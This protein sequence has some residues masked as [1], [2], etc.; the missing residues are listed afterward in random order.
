MTVVNTRAFP[1]PSCQKLIAYDPRHAGGEIV[2]PRCGHRQRVPQGEGQPPPLA[3]RSERRRV[4]LSCLFAGCGG[5]LGVLILIAAL[6]ALGVSVRIPA[7][8]PKVFQRL[9]KPLVSRGYL[10]GTAPEQVTL[11]GTE[12]AVAVSAVA[13]KC[14]L[15]YEAP[16]KRTSA[17]ETP[18]YCVSLT[19]SNGGDSPAAYRSWRVLED[20]SDVRRAATLSDE[21]GSRLGLIS[22]GV[23][24]W[25]V[26]AIGEAQIAPGGSIQDVLLF[27]CGSLTGGDL[28]I[29][30]PGENIGHN[31]P[32]RFRIP[33][34][35]V[36]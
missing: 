15:I 18:V 31:R 25:P 26:G 35:L 4:S 6:I 10:P 33:R 16:L 5:C 32:V 29:N 13:K 1:C 11:A 28:I 12:V 19:I 7:H 27:E 21:A 14:P 30:L 9:S 23:N 17:T 20:E 8:M 22:F 34:E 24:T 2:C 3:A 36:Q